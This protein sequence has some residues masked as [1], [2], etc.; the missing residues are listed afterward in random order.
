M[1]KFFFFVWLKWVT[2]LTLESVLLALLLS[3]SITSYIYFKQGLPAFSS[4][5]IS[6]LLTITQFWFGI[7]WSFTVLL[8]L[9]RGMKYI[10]NSCSDGLRLE[11]LTCP[12]ESKSE[13]IEVVGYG[14][15]VKVWRKWFLLLIWLVA[16]QMVV[17]LIVFY[18]LGSENIF[19]WFSVYILYAFIL[20][21]GYFSFMVLTTRCKRVR[22][23]KC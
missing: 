7:I 8:S 23:A 4:E 15:L 5:V 11:L 1:S 20:V 19:E 12:K 16:S 6:A 22:L 3:L 17:A 13:R 21:A 14:D 10:F 9:F 2:R 18:F